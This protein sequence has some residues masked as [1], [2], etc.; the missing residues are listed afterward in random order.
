MVIRRG[1]YYSNDN[2]AAVLAARF[3]RAG[4]AISKLSRTLL[5]KLICD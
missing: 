1:N 5:S 2:A 4:M 3:K